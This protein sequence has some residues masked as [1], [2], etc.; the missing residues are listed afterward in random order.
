MLNPTW[1]LCSWKTV[2]EKKSSHPFVLWKMTGLW[3]SAKVHIPPL[4]DGPSECPLMSGKN[5]PWSTVQ[6][7]HCHLL[8]P[9]YHTWFLLVSSSSSYKRKALFCLTFETSCR[10]PGW[11]F[12]LLQQSSLTYYYGP[13]PPSWNNPFKYSLSLLKPRGFLFF[14]FDTCYL[15]VYMF[16]CTL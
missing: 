2:T 11:V 10:S 8:I 15:K 16:L 4:C 14:V 3:P 6:S 7:H 12:F 5:C 9:L 13:F 1:A